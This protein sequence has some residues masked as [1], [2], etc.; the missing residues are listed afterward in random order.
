MDSEL[1][2]QRR[3][4]LKSYHCYMAAD[5]SFQVA[6]ESAVSWLPGAGARHLIVTGD[7]GSP[8]RRLYDRRERA[9]ARLRQ[10]RAALEEAR[11]R[12]AEER[13]EQNLSWLIR[14][15]GHSNA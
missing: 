1:T 7:P 2:V 12:V 10:A 3:V 14:L 9:L 6:F 15:I 4:L 8:V 11:L 5:R 13:A